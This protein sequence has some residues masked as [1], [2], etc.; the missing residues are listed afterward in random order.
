M[1]SGNKDRKRKMSHYTG[2]KPQKLFHTR[3]NE[4]YFLLERPLDE[5]ADF[6][7]AAYRKYRLAK[8]DPKFLIPERTS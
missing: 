7:R 3:N 8:A 5:C 4:F 2:E 1:R 6:A